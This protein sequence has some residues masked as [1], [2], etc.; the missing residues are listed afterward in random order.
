MANTQKGR[1]ADAN[2]PLIDFGNRAITYGVTA[3][4]A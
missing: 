4:T 2:P 1:V 3:V